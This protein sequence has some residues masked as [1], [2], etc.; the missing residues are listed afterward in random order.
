MPF[1]GLPSNLHQLVMCPPLP[2]PPPGTYLPAE[3]ISLHQVPRV[4]PGAPTCLSIPG[5]WKHC[6]YLTFSF[7]QL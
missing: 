3:V 6:L 2:A 4:P 1:S 5:H 7:L